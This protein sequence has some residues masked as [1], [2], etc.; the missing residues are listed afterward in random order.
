MEERVEAAIRLLRVTKY[1]ETM[2]ACTRGTQHDGNRLALA[3]AKQAFIARIVDALTLE[4]IE[5][6]VVFYKSDAGTAW[7]SLGHA[8]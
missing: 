1:D 8:T 4:Q 3:R 6:A 2:A 7:A 5:A